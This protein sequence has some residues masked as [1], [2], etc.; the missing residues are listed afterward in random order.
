M[1][2]FNIQYD[3]TRDLALG[4]M[5]VWKENGTDKPMELCL[6]RYTMAKV[7]ANNTYEF[8]PTIVNG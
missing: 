8:D 1:L 2:V 3:K 5:R 7:Y 4:E 6:K